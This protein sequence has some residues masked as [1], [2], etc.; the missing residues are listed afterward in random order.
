[1]KDEVC[2]NGATG[3]HN[4]TSRANPGYEFFVI[5]SLEKAKAYQDKLF[6]G[7]LG[8]SV[9]PHTDHISL[10]EYLHHYKL[11]D[12]LQISIGIKD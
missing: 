11:I 9:D 8:L 2:F 1:V 10:V 5:D 4:C 12:N 6:A 7:I 3:R